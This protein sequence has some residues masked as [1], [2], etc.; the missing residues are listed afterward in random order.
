[1]LVEAYAM[2]AECASTDDIFRSVMG[3]LPVFSVLS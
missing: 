2:Q 3:P 1:M